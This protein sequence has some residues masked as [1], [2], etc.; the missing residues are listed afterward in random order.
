M[1]RAVIRL[2]YDFRWEKMTRFAFFRIYCGILYVCI[3][4]ARRVAGSEQKMRFTRRKCTHGY[5][6]QTDLLPDLAGHD[7]FLCQASFDHPGLVGHNF[8]RDT[9]SSLA[10]CYNLSATGNIDL[11]GLFALVLIAGY[12]VLIALVAGLWLEKRELL[13]Q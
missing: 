6:A 2:S 4:L 3:A 9:T 10:A 7:A 1:S 11:S 8:E 13:L 5:A 12:V